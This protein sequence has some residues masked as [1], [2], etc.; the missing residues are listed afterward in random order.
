ML[1]A[2]LP[3]WL[4]AGCRLRS[5]GVLEL[6]GGGGGG[7]DGLDGL[8]GMGDICTS[9]ADCPGLQACDAMAFSCFACT[10]DTDCNGI[11]DML[12]AGPAS[13]CT[14]AMAAAGQCSAGSCVPQ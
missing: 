3:Y 12:L 1:L 10:A 8:G 7:L 5:G 9:Y 14:A 2:M 6:L 13:C 4:P 11:F